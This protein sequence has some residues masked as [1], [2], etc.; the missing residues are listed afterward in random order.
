MNNSPTPAEQPNARFLW[1]A[2]RTPVGRAASSLDRNSLAILSP[3]TPCFAGCF[4]PTEAN[5]QCELHAQVHIAG[6]EPGTNVGNTARMV[7]WPRAR[8]TS[9]GRERL[10]EV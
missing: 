8:N 1:S 9:G 4:R 3:T 6:T 5:R 10:T 7:S 2:G